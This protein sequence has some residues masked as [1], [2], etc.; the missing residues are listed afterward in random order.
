MQSSFDK[1][2]K[3]NDQ[4]RKP[5][6]FSEK[7]EEILN[8]FASNGYSAVDEYFN[9]KLKNDVRRIFFKGIPKGAKRYVQKVKGIIKHD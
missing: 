9:K 2:A 3:H 6:T 8:T 4:L 7:R 1:V 5:S